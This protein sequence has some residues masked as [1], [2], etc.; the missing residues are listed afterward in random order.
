M[1]ILVTGANGFLGSFLIR[2]NSDFLGIDLRSDSSRVLVGDVRNTETL[3]RVI[4]ENKISEIV[5]LAGVQFSSY[6]KRDNRT[7]FFQQNIEMAKA[8]QSIANNT[9]VKKIVYV[10]TDMVYGDKVISPVSESFIPSPIGEYGASKLT[11]ENVLLDPENNFYTVVLRPRLILGQGRVGTISKLAGLIK[12]PLPIV[13]IGNGKNKYQ[14]VAAEDVC[15]AIE[16]S[17][18]LNVKGI[19]NIGS[20]NPPNL[21]DLFKATLLNLNR[22]KIILKIPMKFAILVFDFLDKLSLSP[23]T[24]EQYKIAGLDFVLDTDKIK[25]ELGWSPTKNDQAMLFDSLNSLIN[26]K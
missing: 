5:H 23:L 13:L 12:S 20:D 19:F 21:D 9:G 14:F 22:T 15:A 25:A 3:A 16:L 24:P 11:A 2:R 1:S 8:L 6:I 10:S 18:R 7:D 4:L 17:L 26:K